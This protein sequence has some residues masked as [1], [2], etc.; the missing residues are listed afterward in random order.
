MSR[1]GG[2]GRI[3]FK[4][5]VCFIHSLRNRISQSNRVALFRLLGLLG[6]LSLV[7]CFLQPFVGKEPEN[8]QKGGEKADEEAKR[9]HGSVCFG[10]IVYWEREIRRKNG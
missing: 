8:E 5:F 6:L 9:K 3:I 10:L 1:G 2:M 4:S 7:L